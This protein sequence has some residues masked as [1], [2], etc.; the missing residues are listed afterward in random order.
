MIRWFKRKKKHNHIDVITT[1]IEGIKQALRNN[2]LEAVFDGLDEIVY[3][4]RFDTHELLWM[5]K[6][7]RET[8]GEDY[9]SKKCFEV[10]QHIDKKCSFCTNEKLQELGYYKPYKWFIANNGVDDTAYF[11]IDMKIRWN[12]SGDA[13]FELAISLDQNTIQQWENQKKD[14]LIQL[15]KH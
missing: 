8:F 10:L 6:K 11:L 4:S 2:D 1:T 5:N 12:G 7:G 15:Q 13:R 3:I 14:N 9:K